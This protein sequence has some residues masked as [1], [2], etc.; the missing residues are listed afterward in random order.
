M[1]NACPQYEDDLIIKNNAQIINITSTYAPK[2][3]IPKKPKYRVTK[4][5]VISSKVDPGFFAQAEKALTVSIVGQFT[6]PNGEYISAFSHTGLS[7]QCRY[8]KPNINP[9]TPTIIFTGRT[10]FKIKVK[11]LFKI[12]VNYKNKKY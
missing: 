3:K 10:L 4:A 1:P 12:S 2:R 11:I 8:Q 9:S 5:T 6:A 7:T